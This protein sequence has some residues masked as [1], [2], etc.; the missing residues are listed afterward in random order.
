M[1]SNI[2]AQMSPSSSKI[3]AK[4]SCT[5]GEYPTTPFIDSLERLFHTVVYWNANCSIDI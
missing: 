2:G 3:F 5:L 4:M 1:G